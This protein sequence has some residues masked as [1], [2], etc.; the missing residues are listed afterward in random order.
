[1]ALIN[2]A[3]WASMQEAITLTGRTSQTI[4]NWI[5]EGLIKT[6]LI[7]THPFYKKEDLLKAKKLKEK[8]RKYGK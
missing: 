2:T 6:Q 5:S 8:N 4:Y 1:M 3:E 7:G